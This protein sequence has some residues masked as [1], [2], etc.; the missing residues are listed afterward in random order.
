M[1][2]AERV[3]LLG[4]MASGKSTVGRL[5]ADRL[6]WSHIDLDAEI[7]R[8]RGMTV[9]EIFAAEGEAAFRALEAELTP[10]LMA[11]DN[12]VLTPGGGWIANAA[13]AAPIPAGTLTVW[14]RAGADEVV[15]R[16]HGQDAPR[17]RP[18]LGGGDLGARV[19]DLLAAREPLYARAA[20]R[21]IET[22][23]RTPAEIAAELA[24][25]VRSNG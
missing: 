2:A 14:L 22:T 15:R 13:V 4:F 21:T 19:E 17:T 12:V 5:L 1:A 9:A 23:G 7:E 16:L 20:H 6:G 3:L 24:D 8:Y 18:L 25:I 10:R 11:R